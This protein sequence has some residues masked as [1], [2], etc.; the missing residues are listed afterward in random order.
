MNVV[1]F[2]EQNLGD[3]GILLDAGCGDGAFLDDLL[4]AANARE[5]WGIDIDEDALS[6]A[7]TY[8]AQVG[9]TCHFRCTSSLNPAL[10]P[11]FSFDSIAFQDL[12]HHLNG[13][14][15][16]HEPDDALRMAVTA[17]LKAMHSLLRPGG[18]LIISECVVDD[19]LP[20]A[21]K[22]RL[23]IHNLKAEVDECHR[24]S[25]SYSMD[26]S[27]LNAILNS[28]LSER[29]YSVV[30]TVLDS[31]D[32]VLTA[33]R[34]DQALEKVLEYFDGYIASL[35]GLAEFHGTLCDLRQ[36]FAL[37]KESAARHGLLP[38]RRLMIIAGKAENP[39]DLP[40][41][42]MFGQ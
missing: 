13:G 14:N 17:H 5:I 8:M 12:L 6:Q 31:S 15:F 35:E 42:G 37:V 34:K 20:R 1:T 40:G 25:H 33:G 4:F 21:R 7:R 29:N 2:L 23:A 19:Q 27:A 16:S 3:L 38:Q 10:P 32:D 39:A 41:E 11:R 9:I 36:R 26:L 24:I 28:F 30:E 22:N 18:R